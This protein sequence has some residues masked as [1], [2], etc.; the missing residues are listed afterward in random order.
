MNDSL[1]TRKNYWSSFYSAHSKYGKLTPPSQFAAFVA[2]ELEPESAIFDVGCGNG[3]D[4]IFFAEMGFKVIALDASEDA[5]KFV[6]K[7]ARERKI[8]NLRAVLSDINSPV[9]RET[10]GELK[11][12]KACVYARFFLHAIS[13]D[14]QEAFF[15]AIS[16][17]LQSG[18]WIAFEYRTAK[19]QPLKK[20]A[21]VHFRRY[22]PAER[23]NEKLQDLGF[24]L[25][26]AIEGQGY[27]KYKTEDAIVARCLFKKI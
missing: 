17:L 6:T 7:A 11:H 22:Q 24:K 26:Y 13:E 10:L 9:F 15:S 4:S 16:D 19:D 3:R 12:N 1:E 18:N 21:P 5:I 20:E 14:E 8:E 25:L 23:V 27:A 2:Q